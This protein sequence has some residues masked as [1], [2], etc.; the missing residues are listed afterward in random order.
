MNRFKQQRELMVKDQIAA[1]G[2][3][4]ARVIEAMKKVP[5]EKFIDEHSKAFAY[6]DRPL[7][8]EEEQ[9]ISQ[10]YIVALM[11]ELAQINPQDKVLEIGTGSGY[12]A[13]ILAELTAKVY[14]IERYPLL[15]KLAK[16]R[17]EDLGYTNITILVGD[18]TIGCKEFAPYNAIIVTAGG[19]QAPSSLLDQLEIGGRLVIP[20]GSTQIYQQLT[21]VTK[22]GKDQFRYENIEAVR[23][24]PLVGK[25]GW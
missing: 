9:T 19:P 12:S 8:I 10:P 16:K 24:V 18:G 3:H 14:S 5:R 21:R 4:D 17:L 20:I 13:A 6:E 15:A 1:R 11:T 23:F 25:E 2:I 7:P 22:I